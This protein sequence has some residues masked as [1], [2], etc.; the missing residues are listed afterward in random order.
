MKQELIDELFKK[1]EAARV[2][3]NEVECWSARDMQAILGYTEWRNFLKVVAKAKEAC[4]NADIPVGDHFV[5][6]NKMVS[7]VLQHELHFAVR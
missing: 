6:I 5:D 3:Y 2:Q 7:T 1:F 4:A